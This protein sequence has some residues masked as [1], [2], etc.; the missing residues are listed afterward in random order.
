MTEAAPTATGPP[1]QILLIRH[2]EKPKNPPSPPSAPC[3][4]PPCGVDVNGVG[5]G[6]SLIPQGWQR[7][8]ALAVLFDPE[9]G[10]LR[11]PL[12]RPDRIYAPCYAPPCT[13]PPNADTI[14]HRTYETISPLA[15]RLGVAIECLYETSQHHKV[16]GMLLSDVGGTTLVCWEHENIPDIAQLIPL[17]PNSPPIPSSGWPVDENND[18]RFDVIWLF[19]LAGPE[20]EYSFAQL[21]QLLLAT[22][23]GI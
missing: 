17:A 23:T 8:G 9:L 19:T 15:Q 22:D 10:P 1:E 13:T 21:P 14:N 7:A 2:G 18:P 4:Q 3:T 20:P 12:T 11:S 5:N 6:D 16:V